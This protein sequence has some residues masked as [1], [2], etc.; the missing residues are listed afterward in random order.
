MSQQR[1]PKIQDSLLLLLLAAVPLLPSC[2]LGELR[3]PTP[4]EKRLGTSERVL[5]TLSP[6]RSLPA[7]GFLLPGVTVREL[8]P[9]LFELTAWL[10][11]TLGEGDD[12]KLHW[13]LTQESNESVL[14]PTAASSPPP[15]APPLK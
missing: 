4:K 5:P 11:G 7:A 14:V 12:L 6:V 2:S 1:L 3:P 13:R 10:N 15:P 8:E 9:E